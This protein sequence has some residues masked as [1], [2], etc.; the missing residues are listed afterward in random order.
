MDLYATNYLHYGAP[1]TWLAF[2]IHIS[3]DV[4]PNWLYPDPQN[5]MY[6]DPAVSIDTELPFPFPG[7]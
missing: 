3:S 4:D 7:Q 5:L 1:K 2:V 6:P